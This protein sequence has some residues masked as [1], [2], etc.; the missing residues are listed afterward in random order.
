MNEHMAPA[1]GLPKSL[2]LKDALASAAGFLAGKT[3][4]VDVK[5]KLK[6]IQS[7]S[8]VG[9]AMRDLPAAWRVFRDVEVGDGVIDHVVAGPR[10]V[11]NIEVK[12]YSG[13]V[14][15]N[16]R[17]LQTDGHRHNGPVEMAMLRASKLEARLG[18]E[19][20]PVLAI[21]GADLTGDTVDGLP[22]VK[23]EDLT[24]YLLF[25]DGRRL[26]WEEARRVFDTLSL[27]TR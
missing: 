23:L 7:E 22:I 24:S 3:P 13:P 27:M 6:R 15:A 16:A 5:T 18:I 8:K 2:V 17:G 21:V 11:Y 12:S 10:G 14:V 26:S 19:V 1:R 9:R 4:P 20:Q 25:D